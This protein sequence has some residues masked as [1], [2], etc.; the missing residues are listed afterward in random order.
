[1]FPESVQ[2]DW[3]TKS[4]SRLLLTSKFPPGVLEDKDVPETLGDGVLR[5]NIYQGMF[6]ASLTMIGR[7]K[8]CQDSFCPPSLLLES[9]RTRMFLIH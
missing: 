3:L 8:A 1:M 4:L 2:G 7:E 6:P 9:W 5:V